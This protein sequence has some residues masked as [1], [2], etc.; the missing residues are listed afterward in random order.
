MGLIQLA[1]ES[2][3]GTAQ[4]QF[5]TEI[6]CEDMGNQVLMRRKT[7]QERIIRN[8]S[9]II[10]NPGQMAVF[11]DNG[12]VKDA[13]AEPGT[14]RWDSQ[15]SPSFFSGNFKGMFKEMWSRFSFGGGTY[16]DQAVYFLNTTEIIDNGFGTFAPVMYRDWEHCMSNVRI[17]GG[18]TPMRVG[19]RCSGNYTFAID[20]PAQFMMRIG[21]TAAIYDKSDL[22]DQMRMEIVSVFQAVL[23]SLCDDMNRIYPLDLPAQSFLIKELMDAKTFDKN[24]RQRGIKVLG[25][26]VL[27]VNLDEESKKKI[28]DYERS[29]DFATQQAVMVSAVKGAAE[30]EGGGAAMGFMNLNMMNSAMGGGMFQNTVPQPT[31]VQQAQPMYSQQAQQ[32]AQPQQQVQQQPQQ[33]VQQ[34]QQG[35]VCTN[36]GAT[37]TGKFCANCGTQVVVQ[38][39]RFCTNCGNKLTG[40]FCAN[41]G[42][43][44]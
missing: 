25:F 16:Q 40:V 44:N 43:K 4:S 6:T 1:K 20:D 32:Y 8:G 33:Q 10:V 27:N 42:T 13:A 15:A 19:I 29:G 12:T 17:P 23:N 22:C 21:G 18:Q 28:D 31:V 35:S 30:N 14:Y 26:N 9:V 2:I 38:Q 41:C 3:R 36:C 7:T 37:V 34:Q 11:V 39:D 5:L 24:I